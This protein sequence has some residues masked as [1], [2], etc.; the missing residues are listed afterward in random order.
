MSTLR[1]NSLLNAAG[2]DTP[3]IDGL[4]KAWVNFQGTGTVDIRESFNV[5]T[6]T[7]NGVGDYTVNFSNA[8]AD[9]NYVFIA[10]AGNGS[11]P[12]QT[13]GTS[14]TGAVPTTTNAR[15]LIDKGGGSPQDRE[16]VI[17][18]VFR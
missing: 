1:V 8:M 4:A 3:A 15:V 9:T 18:A 17:V 10:Q 11:S 12:I 6:I 14:Y 13:A 16:Y 2:T 5:S 7:D